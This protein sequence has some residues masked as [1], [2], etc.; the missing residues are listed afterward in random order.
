MCNFVGSAHSDGKRL[1]SAV[2]GQLKPTS[3]PLLVEKVAVQAGHF[4]LLLVVGNY[5]VEILW[6]ASLHMSPCPGFAAFHCSSAQI[7]QPG[8]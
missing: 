7:E 2:A 3:T 8:S 5:G 6:V 4:S 1:Q